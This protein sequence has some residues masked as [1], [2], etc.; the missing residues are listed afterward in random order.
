MYFRASFYVSG[1]NNHTE[2]LLVLFVLS[3]QDKK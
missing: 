2:D 1:K 3:D